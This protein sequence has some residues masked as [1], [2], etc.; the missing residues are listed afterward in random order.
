MNHRYASKPKLTA[1]L[2]VSCQISAKFG[3]CTVVD[4]NG[5]L[6]EAKTST[7]PPENVRI[8]SSTSVPFRY[9]TTVKKPYLALVE[10]KRITVR[11]RRIRACLLN[12]FSKI[13]FGGIFSNFFFILYSAL[14]FTPCRFLSKSPSICFPLSHIHTC[15]AR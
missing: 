15:R 10:S 14:Y 9:K 2:S 12:F 3:F 13:F 7:S 1:L 11:G 4:L 6:V 8:L 5:T